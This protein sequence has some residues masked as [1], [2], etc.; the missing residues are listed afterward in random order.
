MK[1]TTLAQVV[2]NFDPKLTLRGQ[3]L[4]FWY[5]ERPDS[6]RGF[7][8]TAL[9]LAQQGQ[10]PRKVLFVGH[11]GSGKSTELYKL[12]SELEESYATIPFDLLDIVGSGEVGYQDVMR[13]L[14]MSLPKALI[15]R[16]WI[17]APAAQ[18]L[19][20]GWEKLGDWWR[21]AVAGLSV[22]SA[23]EI[24]TYASLNTLLG[25]VEVGA[26]VS[27]YDRERLNQQVER[28]MPELIRYLNAVIAEA[29]SV[30]APRRL[31]VVIEGLDKID[32]EPAR[33][34]FRD[35][36]TTI[37]AIDVTTIFTFPLAL[38]YAEDY[39]TVLRNFDEDRYLH[40]FALCIM[41][42]DTENR[43]GIEGLRKIVLNRLE[44]NLVSDAALNYIVH[45]S[46]GIP[47][48][49][50]R[51]VRGAA[52]YALTRDAAALRIELEDVQNIARDLRRE[53]AAGLSLAQWRHLSAR[54]QDRQLSNTPDTRELLYRAALIEYS[55]GRQWCDVHPLLWDLLDYYAPD[56]ETEQGDGA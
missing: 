29:Q 4:R 17:R 42:D 10:Q 3:D 8:R 46:G 5:V 54:R 11:R 52:I 30:L 41:D 19:R 35:Y 36:A 37:T 13:T 22:G 21:D 26:N 39:D 44:S 50:V 15:D 55:N 6:P 51:L 31:L 14:G 32:L 38:R 47:S 43:T 20:D 56:D 25:E 27:S 45:M 24:T 53:R 23:R 1:A 7:L 40:N 12:A 48:D 2:A 16:G 49:L 9:T 34:I 18:P 33:N 28:H